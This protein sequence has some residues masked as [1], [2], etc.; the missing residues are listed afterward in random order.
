MAKITDINSGEEY[1][2]EESL[3]RAEKRMLAKSKKEAKKKK[4]SRVRK[5]VGRILLGVLTVVLVIVAILLV[6]YR[7][8]INID[9]FMRMI[10]YI[11]LEKDEDG[12][13]EEI[14]YDNDDSNCFA[15]VSDSLLVCSQSS[16]QLF[17]QSGNTY[18][19]E[20]ITMTTPTIHVDGSYAVVYDQGGTALYGIAGKQISYTET[21]EGTILNARVNS[22][23]YLTLITKETG[24]KGVI[25]VYDTSFT[26]KVQISISS[27][28]VMD[29]LVSEDGSTLAI[30]S[31]GADDSTYATTVSFYDTSTG[32]LIDPSY[33]ISGSIA[34]DLRWEEDGLL[35]QMDNGIQYI[36]LEEGIVSSWVNS[37]GYLRGYSFT[38]DG[39]QVMIW[40][41]YQTGYQ[42]N[43]VLVD[44][45]GS[46]VAE[47]E[48]S[49]EVYSVSTAENY[50]ALLYTNEL[51]IY[52]STLTE[53]ASLVDTAG[54][55][56]AIVRNDGSAL[57]LGSESATLFVP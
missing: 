56:Q 30:I 17:S 31:I 13:A 40:S 5:I 12:Q 2:D 14:F 49:Q 37:D 25:T 57:L 52:D 53:Y 10:S 1:E 47:M 7:D 19:S 22:N 6:V 27:S 23:G 36:T 3:T 45:T 11:S 20:Y 38:D 54:S 39:Y 28:Y 21:T 24:Y 26:A 46:E 44:L 55:R 35:L 4:K 18:I 50:I 51:V 42:G 48:I 41:T 32:E 43:L 15:Q 34:L 16:I 33:S 29:A 8:E 9:S